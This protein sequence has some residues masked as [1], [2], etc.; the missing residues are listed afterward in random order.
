MK[1]VPGYG[2]VFQLG[3]VGTERALLGPVVV[4]E[5]VDG[6]VV[7]E[8]P[9]L[10]ADLCWR[11]AGD[12]ALGMKI[13]GTE[14]LRGYTRLVPSVVTANTPV[15][16]PCVKIITD[17][18]SVIASKDHP[19]WVRQKASNNKARWVTAIHLR[20]GYS[21]SSMPPWET[22]RSWEAGYLAGQFDGEGSL[23]RSEDTRALSYC[24]RLGQSQQYVRQLL[25]GLGFSLGEDVRRRS[26]SWQ[27]IWTGKIT[28]G[29]TE[30]LRFLGSIRPVRLLERAEDYWSGSC[31]N[32]LPRATVLAVE[33]AGDR[34]V[35]GL[36]TSTHTYIAGGLVSHNSQF[37]LGI[38]ED[39]EL[40]MRSHHQVISPE[41]C[42]DMFRGAVD[43]VCS[44]DLNWVSPNTYFYCEV[45]CKPKH[46][47]IAYGRVPLNHLVLFDAS[48]P[49]G[50]FDRKHLGEFEMRLGIDLVPELYRGF[51]NVET[52]RI[53]LSTPSFLG[54]SI[55]E[56]V[57]VKNYHETVAPGGRMQPLFVKLVNE[58]FKEQNKVD[59]KDRTLRGT[60][61]AYVASFQ[62]E[63]RW[64]KAVQHLRDQGLLQGE[65]RDIG[66]LVKEIDRDIKDEEEDNI[67]DAL[68]KLCIHEIL[69]KAKNGLPEW[70]KAKL[71]EWSDW[72]CAHCGRINPGTMPH[73]PCKEE[74]EQ[75]GYEGDA[76]GAWESNQEYQERIDGL[77]EE[78]SS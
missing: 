46:N 25:L 20:P 69:R 70:Y 76:S 24:Q 22:D 33:D 29:W 55:V 38:N 37:G 36:S 66:S 63:A 73:C 34:W 30:G 43:Y 19:L 26:D 75:T 35:S 41:N 53:L 15:R 50:W 52:L 5:K 39:G 23:V 60:V 68:Y 47:T 8:T 4:Q 1:E 44:L 9:I 64:M 54:G 27:E 14:V 57:V 72:S 61:E 3:S 13:I 56:G 18:G 48:S 51:V 40:V 45:L 12:L 77:T 31:M 65:P 2:K 17:V 67:K 74:V 6:C 62:N 10:C 71:I 32:Y 28:G 58:Q 78:V 7:P 21:I 16:K 49:D 11:P 42:P 59:F